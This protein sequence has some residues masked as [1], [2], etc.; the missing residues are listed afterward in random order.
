MEYNDKPNNYDESLKV[1]P[2]MRNETR[3]PAIANYI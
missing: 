3:T 2:E 1:S